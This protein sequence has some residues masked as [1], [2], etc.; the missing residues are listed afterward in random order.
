MFPPTYS[1]EGSYQFKSISACANM[2]LRGIY[3]SD[4]LY[5]FVTLPQDMKYKFSF[6]LQRWLEFFDWQSLPTD[7]DT[8]DVNDSQF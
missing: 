7:W 4:N 2:Q 1:I 5:D 8:M 3:T 6:E